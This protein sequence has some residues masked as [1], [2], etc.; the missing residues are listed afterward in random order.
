[1]TTTT[2]ARPG[3]ATGLRGAWTSFRAYRAYRS[4]LAELAS[5]S[6]R[7]LADLGLRR[8]ALKRTAREAAYR[9]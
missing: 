2:A 1:M 3:T 8:D 7:E 5:L 6:D 9:I 4:T